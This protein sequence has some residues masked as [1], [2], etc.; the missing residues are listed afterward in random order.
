MKVAYLL[1]LDVEKHLGVK[2]KILS[3]CESMEKNGCKVEIFVFSP[4]KTNSIKFNIINTLNV[5]SK[6][7][8]LSQILRYLNRTLSVNKMLIEID[9]FKPDVIYYRE[10]VYFPGLNKIF[11]KYKVVCEVNTTHLGKREKIGNS[12]LSYFGS[13]IRYRGYKYINGFVAVSNEIQYEHITLGYMPSIVICNGISHID[14]KQSKPY[15]NTDNVNIVM[16]GSPNQS[17]QGYE[18]FFELSKLLDN[19][20][21]SYYLIGPRSE[22]FQDTGYVK[23]LGYL[24]EQELNKFLEKIDVAMGSLACFK[25]D[26]NEVSSLKHRLYASKRLPFIASVKDTDFSTEPF[27]L[28]LPNN[29][30]CIKDHL[31]KIK[32]FI[33]MSTKIDLYSEVDLSIYLEMT[34]ANERVAFLKTVVCR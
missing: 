31:N 19:V 3:Q 33:E 10:N 9:R 18:L 7:K 13:L 20:N 21:Y 16:V 25:K 32:E 6:N 1:E 4:I 29:E 15:K 24:Q 11:K 17:W 2:N 5:N 28:T 23:C 34:K 27:M 12:V 22:D 8:L 14:K 26:I 30:R